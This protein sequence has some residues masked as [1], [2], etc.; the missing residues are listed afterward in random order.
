MVALRIGQGTGDDG[1]WEV[2]AF[3]DTCRL[4]TV[5]QHELLS[6]SISS[7][8]TRDVLELGLAL[9]FR[10]IVHHLS[11]LIARSMVHE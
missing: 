4:A 10:L 3:E 2:E 1:V 11:G 8:A 6:V 9:R 7:T 5:G